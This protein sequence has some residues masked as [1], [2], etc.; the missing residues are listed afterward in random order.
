MKR[1]Y[2]CPKVRIGDWVYIREKYCGY[3]SIYKYKVLALREAGKG[4]VVEVKDNKEDKCFIVGWLTDNELDTKRKYD[5]PSG[6][7][8]WF[9]YLWEKVGKKC[10]SIE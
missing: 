8:A 3:D 4:I 2:D 5:L 10:L 7:K 9:V 1:K 6:T